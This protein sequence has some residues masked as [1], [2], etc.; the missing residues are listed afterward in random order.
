MAISGCLMIWWLA[1]RIGQC[2]VLEYMGKGSLVIYAFNIS[3]L[4]LV[5]HTIIYKVGCPTTPMLSLVVFVAI[6]FASV[7]VLTALY[8]LLN[9]KYLRLFLGKF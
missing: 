9:H 5:A 4:N 8:W 2:R 3:V 6:I 7:A 1:Q